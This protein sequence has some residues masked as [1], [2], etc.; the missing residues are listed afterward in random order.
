[1]DKVADG[2]GSEGVAY[3][4][5]VG[6]FFVYAGFIIAIKGTQ[7]LMETGVDIS[8]ED[9]KNVMVEGKILSLGIGE[10]GYLWVDGKAGEDT[11]G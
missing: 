6:V 8:H 9:R 10:C 5:V 1:M 11:K 2:D 7:I 3:I 4:A